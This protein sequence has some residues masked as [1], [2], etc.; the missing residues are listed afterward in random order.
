MYQKILLAYDGSS[1]AKRALEVALSLARLSGAQVRALAVEEHLP[2]FAATVSEME[3]EKE[4][5]NHYYQRC[6][7]AAF[8]QALQ[9]G[10]TLEYEIRVGSAAR[11]IVEVAKEY[12]CDLVIL[13]GSGR[14]RV[15]G[16]VLGSTAEKVSSQASCS[17]LLA[18]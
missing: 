16:M 1:G 10:V 7:S 4:F 2:H 12:Q 17:V 14:S 11:T 9:A 13:G 3:G 6:L 5:A 18:R 15:L 8:L